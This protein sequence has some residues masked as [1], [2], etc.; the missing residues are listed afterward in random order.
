MYW[1]NITLSIIISVMCIC[2]CTCIYVTLIWLNSNGLTGRR[3][4]VNDGEC[5]DCWIIV[6]QPD[7]RNV[8]YLSRYIHIYILITVKPKPIY[9]TRFQCTCGQS[10]TFGLP[11]Y[12][13]TYA[14]QNHQKQWNIQVA[15]RGLI[16]VV[17]FWT[18]S[19]NHCHSP[20]MQHI[21][22]PILVLA[23]LSLGPFCLATS[24]IVVAHML[25]G[26]SVSSTRK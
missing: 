11:H 4:N 20:P 22:S 9:V 15:Q 14:Y 24:Q 13:H 19:F 5:K 17:K 10:T 6:F 8:M 18:H 7:I 26:I 25:S 3:H 21:G 23:H 12:I 1:Y 2:M 16:G